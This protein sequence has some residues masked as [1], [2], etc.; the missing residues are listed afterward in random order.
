MS[1]TVA[2]IKSSQKVT[3]L[4]PGAT[5]K[6]AIEKLDRDHAEFA[7]VLL[8]K[9]SILGIFTGEDLTRPGLHKD[10]KIEEVMSVP[11]LC[12]LEEASLED[13][14][15]LMHSKHLKVIP[16]VDSEGR[17]QRLVTLT[18]ALERRVE[19]LSLECKDLEK[20]IVEDSAGG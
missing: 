17:Y 10:V 15:W 1:T 3:S 4:Y 8:N 19:D 14:L 2:D 6:E 7:A 5:I 16:V 13:L 20:F 12:V 11:E 18:D 9:E